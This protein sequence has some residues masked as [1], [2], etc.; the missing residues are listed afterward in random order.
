MNERG[1]IFTFD[2][3]FALTLTALIISYSGLAFV[4]SRRQVESYVTRSSLERIAND[5]ADV[6]IKTLGRPENW[7]N[8]AENLEVL[9]LAEENG[10][11]PVPN[12]VSILKFSQLKRLLNSDNWGATVNENAVE[13]IKKFFGGSE[14]FSV[15]IL[16]DNENEMWHAFPNWSTGDLG[17]LSGAENSFEVVTVRRLVAVRYGSAIR[18]DSGIV[19]ISPGQGPPESSMSFEI[20]NQTELEAYDWYVVVIG[21]DSNPNVKIRINDNNAEPADYGNDFPAIYPAQHGGIYE[22]AS[23]GAGRQLFV[24]TNW[25]AWKFTALGP[26]DDAWG[27]IYL[28]TVP[29]CSDFNLASQFIQPLPGT[30]EVKVWA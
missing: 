18:S 24:G 29:H 28:V 4:Q 11:S 22:D 16:D 23:I 10:G 13:N 2:M 19:G 20:L 30:L 7:E 15:R 8:A 12:T 3:F 5:A 6:M 26:G 14:K 21:I 25:I 9:G 1:Q 27:R 17:E